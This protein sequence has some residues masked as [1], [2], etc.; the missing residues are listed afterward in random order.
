MTATVPA[1]PPRRYRVRTPARLQMEATECGAASLGIVLAHYGRWVTLEELRDACGISRDGSTVEAIERAAQG[2][3]LKVTR[4]RCEPEELKQQRLP[5]I[6]FWSFDHFLV[7]EGWRGDEWYLSD[8]GIGGHRLCSSDDFDDLFTGVALICEPGPE[9]SRSRRPPNALRRLGKHLQGSRD[10]IWFML[11]LGIL[12]IAPTVL[13]PGVARLFTDWLTGG[14]PVVLTT[15]LGVLLGATVLQASMIGLQGSVGMRLATKLS[16]VLQAT[17]MTRLLQLPA[18]FHAQRGPA[19]L[20]QRAGQPDQ[21]ATTVSGLFSTFVVGVLSSI[22]ALL[23]MTVAYPPAGLTALLALVA[24]IGTR[25]ASSRRRKMLAMR[26][27]REQIEAGTVSVSSLSQI[28]VIKASGAEDHAIR[29]WT[30]AHNRLLAATQEFGE[31]KVLVN[32]MPRFVITAGTAAVTIVGLIGV[33]DGSLSL[34]GFLTVQT[35]LGLALGPAGSVVSQL[36]QAETLNGQ[37]DQMDDVLATPL[38]VRTAPREEPRPAVLTGA[39]ELRGVTFGY[40]RGRPA[41]LRDFQLNLAP[42]ARIALVGASGCGKSTVGRLLV[43]LY[44]P[45]QGEVLIDGHPRSWWPEQVLCEQLAIV[46]QDP[47]IFA[48]SFR[49]NLTLWDPTVGEADMIRAAVDAALHDEIARRPGAYDAVLRQGGTDLSGG[50]RQRLEIARALVRDP[51]ID[52]PGRGDVGAGR[53]QRGAHRRVAAAARGLLPAH[54]APA[55]HRPGCRRNHR[56]GGGPSR[57]AGPA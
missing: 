11:L 34:G 18:A 32:L 13:I 43:G 51:A 42:G 28:E 1:G 36:D 27:V 12:L 44:E 52:D 29:R 5:A 19:A 40:D 56:H 7:V 6:V 16:V 9:F 46:D 49:D 20:A 33:T 45:W 31:R 26:M 15:L 48:G 17:M 53:G 22:T 21:V 57:R 47:V 8:P 3:G 10:G 55:V 23:V 37:L 4:C 35:L 2:Y 38:P 24:V 50:Q 14:P 39:V 30:A 41:L 54:R 25:I